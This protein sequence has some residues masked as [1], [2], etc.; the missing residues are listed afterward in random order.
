MKDREIAKLASEYARDIVVAKV[1]ST[2]S[3]INAGSGKAVADFYVEIYK[4]IYTA[5]KED[6]LTEGTKQVMRT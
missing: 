5:L 1:P 3:P 4:G 6:L 2:Q